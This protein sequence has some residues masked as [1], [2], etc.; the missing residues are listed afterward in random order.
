MWYPYLFK[1]VQHQAQKKAV[2]KMCE[3]DFCISTYLSPEYLHP[4]LVDQLPKFSVS[5]ISR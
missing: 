3:M 1:A 5:Y 4:A 2:K